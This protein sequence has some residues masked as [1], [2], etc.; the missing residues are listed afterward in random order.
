MYGAIGILSA[1]WSRQQSNEGQHVDV[2]LL[3]TPISWL[4]WE[5]A[6][7]FATGEVPGRLGS[8]HRLGVPYQAFRCADGQHITIGASGNKA[9]AQICT[10]VGM[11][12]LVSDERFRSGDRRLAN[13]AELGALLDVAFQARPAAE[14]LAALTEAG[15]PCGPINTVD[16][17]LE[18]DEHVKAR[19]MV[20]GLDHPVV[21]PTRAL[22]TPINLSETPRSVRRPAPTLGQHT[23]EVLH[24][25]GY[26]DDAI[27]G[28][29]ASGAIK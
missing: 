29:R 11:P 1:L 7:L 17:V 23:T 28:L 27:A 13:R 12:E 25:I 20:V 14:W 26:S 21:G 22:A 5:A 8:G 3:D 24:W 15:V 4:V 19:G 9:F 18:R 6:S 2:C 10:I 16:H